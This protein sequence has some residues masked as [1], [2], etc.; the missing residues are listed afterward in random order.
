M[1]LPRRPNA[2]LGLPSNPSP[3]SRTLSAPDPQAAVPP[4]PSSAAALHSGSS[5]PAAPQADR[6]RPQRSLTSLRGE[7]GT[8]RAAGRAR[9]DA[10]PP[11]PPLPPLPP[12]ATKPGTSTMSAYTR[13]NGSAASLASASSTSSSAYASPAA[14][15]ESF[16]SVEDSA[17]PDEKAPP[18]LAPGFDS[19]LWGRVAAAAGNLSVNINRAWEANIGLSSGEVTPPG[20]E[21]R[22]S[23][24][25]KAYHIEKA[26]DPSDLPEWLFSER[27]RGVRAAARAAEPETQR[28]AAPAPEPAARAVSPPRADPRARAKREVD[29][30]HAASMSRAAQK[31]RELRDQKAA[32]RTPTIRFAD[33]PHPRHA[34]GARMQAPPPPPPEE[35]PRLPELPEPRLVTNVRPVASL[36]SVGKRPNAVG[37]PTSVRP[38]RPT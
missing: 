27:E 9:T 16:T 12:P 7:L 29:E 8:E 1:A 37:L 19:S 38:R 30:E 10:R 15:D 23:K 22:L 28:A 13:R 34:G 25:I 36:K 2:R 14:S 3:R 20:E 18:A 35:Q 31:L 11:V 21:S 4:R 6:I 32:K 17:D 5:S 33:T 24:A 26:R